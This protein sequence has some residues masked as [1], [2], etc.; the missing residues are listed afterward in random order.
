M[1]TA[2]QTFVAFVDGLQVVVQAGTEFADDDPIVRA[3]PDMFTKAKR[4]TK[5]S[6]KA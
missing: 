2:T 6:T 1:A 5:R 3:C 4:T